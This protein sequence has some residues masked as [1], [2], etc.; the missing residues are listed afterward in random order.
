MNLLSA[1]TARTGSSGPRRRGSRQ[2]PLQQHLRS[3]GIPH[4]KPLQLLPEVESAVIAVEKP[5]MLVVLACRVEGVML[6]I[7]MI[8]PQ[9]NMLLRKDLDQPAR[10]AQQPGPRPYQKATVLDYDSPSGSTPPPCATRSSGS[11]SGSQ[12]TPELT[13][14]GA[15][16]KFF[17]SSS[18]TT[19]CRSSRLRSMGKQ[20]FCKGEPGP[21]VPAYYSEPLS[22]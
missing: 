20:R 3:R 6:V 2:R 8:E 22:R 10:G 1:A 18:I 19:S 17:R 12:P 15:F 14:M 11:H 7:V 16:V 4:L 5:G 13:P 9:V 21:R